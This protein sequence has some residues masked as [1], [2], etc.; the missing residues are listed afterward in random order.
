MSI[1]A[2]KGPPG[3]GFGTYSN[4]LNHWIDYS[5]ILGGEHMWAIDQVG[6]LMIRV[7]V[8]IYKVAGH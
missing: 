4:G 3:M 1:G 5:V 7:S 6:L 2:A 8:T